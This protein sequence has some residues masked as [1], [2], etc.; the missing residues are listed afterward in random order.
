MKVGD[1][2]RTLIDP[3]N[4]DYVAAGLHKGMVGI[5]TEKPRRIWGADRWIAEVRFFEAPDKIWAW[6]RDSLEVVDA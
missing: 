2:V 3:T 6:S 5:V 1:I 4:T